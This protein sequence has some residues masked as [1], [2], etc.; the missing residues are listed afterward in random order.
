MSEYFIYTLTDPNTKKIFYVGVTTN[1]KIRS[2]AHKYV[3]AAKKLGLEESHNPRLD[4]ILKNNI[5]PAFEILESAGF[6][7]QEAFRIEAFWIWMF[8]SW[9]FDLV[10]KIVKRKA[11]NLHG[12]MTDMKI[13][14]YNNKEHLLYQ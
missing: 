14:K 6:D 3:L 7:K 11:R 8:R 1:P 4:Y 5:V 13:L 9:G 2:Q 12:C 10:N